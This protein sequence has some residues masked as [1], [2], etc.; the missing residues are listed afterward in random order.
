M[1]KE[2]IESLFPTTQEIIFAGIA[3][4]CVLLILLNIIITAVLIK[5]NEKRINKRL[6]Q[7]Q[8][9]LLKKL[10]E[11]CANSGGRSEIAVARVDS[12][13]TADKSVKKFVPDDDYGDLVTVS[14]IVPESD[15]DNVDEDLLK[16]TE[17]VDDSELA[18]I[19]DEEVAV[20]NPGKSVIVATAKVTNPKNTEK[21]ASQKPQQKS[22]QKPQ[23]QKKSGNNNRKKF[24]KQK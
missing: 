1:I 5:R 20:H 15:G 22:Q 2:F 16:V 12:A 3:V 7:Q 24:K 17:E 10:D 11:L 18:K 6:I 21:G 9:E 23:Q 13:D 8:S 14:D 19:I 4:A